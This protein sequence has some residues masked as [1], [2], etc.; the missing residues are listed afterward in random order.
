MIRSSGGGNLDVAVG[1]RHNFDRMPQPLHQPGVIGAQVICFPCRQ[2]GAEDQVALKSL[3]SLGQPEA[4]P[5]IKFQL[6]G[7]PCRP[8]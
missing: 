3:G 5:G 1:T 8:F 4:L 2:V 6:P 7:P